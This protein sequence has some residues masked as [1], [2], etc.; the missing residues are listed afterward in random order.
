MFRNGELQMSTTKSTRFDF[1]GFKDEFAKRDVVSFKNIWSGIFLPL[2]SEI[3]FVGIVVS[4]VNRSSNS[5]N[6]I[7]ISDKEMN[8]ISILLRGGIKVIFLK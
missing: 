4:D 1:Q 3:D 2:F 5:C 6:E 7:Y 8:I